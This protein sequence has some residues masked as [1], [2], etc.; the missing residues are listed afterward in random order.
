MALTDEN[1]GL[2]AY[3]AI[4]AGAPDHLLSG[5]R[6]LVEIGPT[7]AEAVSALF[8]AAGLENITVHPDLN[9]RDRVVAAQKSA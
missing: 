9:D 1:D 5:G 7:Q 8:N 3:R 2:D 6:I 4:A